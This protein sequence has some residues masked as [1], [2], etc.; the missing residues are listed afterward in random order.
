MARE[1]RRYQVRPFL[2]RLVRMP[3]TVLVS[4]ALGVL[5]TQYGME[6]TDHLYDS[7]RPVVSMRAN[8][9]SRGSDYVVV[10]LVAH[11]YRPCRYARMQAYAITAEH[12]M[13]SVYMERIDIPE[14]GATRPVG[15]EFDAGLWRI[16]PTDG[17]SSVALYAHHQCE[18]RQVSTRVADVKL[19]AQK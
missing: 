19:G 9:A 1:V 8:V 7:V 5:A 16:W 4:I 6:W 2:R 11:K 13:R 17:A 15:E 12:I 10:R 3:V 18:D 14:S